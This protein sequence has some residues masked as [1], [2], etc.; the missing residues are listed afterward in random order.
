[1]DPMPTPLD[2]TESPSAPKARQLAT[3]F[4][5]HWGG[6]FRAVSA[7][8]HSIARELIALLF[9]DIHHVHLSQALD[10]SGFESEIFDSPHGEVRFVFEAQGQRHGRGVFA[11]RNS[12]SKTV[13]QAPHT[14]NDPW[15][16]KLTGE[17]MAHL[18]VRAAAWNTVSRNATHN[19]DIARATRS[20]FVA[21]ADAAIDSI[22]DPSIIQVHG[23]N[24]DR[25]TT[26]AGRES[27]AIVSSGGEHPA[28]ET[29]Q[30]VRRLSRHL[31]HV[32]L[33]P[34]DVLELGAT[35]NPVGRR[36]RQRKAGAF[37]H[38]EMSRPLRD[39]LRKNLRLSQR[40][41]RSLIA[42]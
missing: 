22:P 6:E 33:Y 16:G 12:D 18:D 8:E 14:R 39:D 28:R 17:W 3:A 11:F 32:K 13:L 21:M 5:E 7:E 41:G 40:I 42:D 4:G 9:E 19:S 30:I 23:F 27:S 26:A 2:I 15:T 37:T 35:G 29:R 38:V 25:R 20:Y 34:L 10:Q 36:M 24:H 1:M 31:D